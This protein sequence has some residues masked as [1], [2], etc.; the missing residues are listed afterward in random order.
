[1][2][3][4]RLRSFV[5][6]RSSCS[7]LFGL[8]SCSMVIFTPTRFQK[9]KFYP[10]RMSTT[11]SGHQCATDIHLTTKTSVSLNFTCKI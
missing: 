4:Q 7:T 8:Y 10:S 1:M 9:N 3:I 2:Y 6:W 5:L 11:G